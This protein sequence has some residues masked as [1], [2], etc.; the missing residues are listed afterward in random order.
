VHD[1]IFMTILQRAS[2][3]PCELPCN[4]LPQST[5][6]DYIVK[7]LP[8]IYVLEYHVVMVL[9]HNH[10]AHTAYVRVVEQLR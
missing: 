5:M 6:A 1:V 2:D 9:M 7:H 8:A 10:I 4:A 3:L